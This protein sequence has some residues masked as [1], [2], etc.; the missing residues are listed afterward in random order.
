MKPIALSLTP[1]SYPRRLSLMQTLN[2]EGSVYNKTSCFDL[3]CLK[4][5]VRGSRV[6]LVFGFIE[7]SCVVV[8]AWKAE[9]RVEYF[10]EECGGTY[11]H[12]IEDDEDGLVLHDWV[13]PPSTKLGDAIAASCEDAKVGKE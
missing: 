9:S 12:R 4:D 11:K 2:T 10:E 7:T 5:F 13:A 6:E 3:W 8:L 1:R